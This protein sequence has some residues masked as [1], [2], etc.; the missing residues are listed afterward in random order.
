M[1]TCDNM[2]G[3]CPT[4]DMSDSFDLA[5]FNQKGFEIE[6]RNHLRLLYDDSMSF[7]REQAMYSQ[8]EQ[9]LPWST[10]ACKCD[11]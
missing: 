8:N 10:K 6:I 3:S 1:I 5:I 9:Y 11:S 7:A 4:K 2:I